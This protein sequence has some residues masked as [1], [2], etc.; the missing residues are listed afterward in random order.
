MAPTIRRVLL[1]ASLALVLAA[2][3][4]A[5]AQPGSPVELPGPG[6]RVRVE[7]PSFARGPLVGRVDSVAA[8]TLFL[9]GAGGGLRAIPVG[10]VRG[11][12]VSRGSR[13]LRGGT[14]GAVIGAAAGGAVVTSLIAFTDHDCDY[15]LG[16]GPDVLALAFAAGAMVR[17]L[18]G[19]AVGALLGADRWRP[20]PPAAQAGGG[21]R[22]GLSVRR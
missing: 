14:R 8:D 18:P 3:G 7:A 12:Q 4:A 10:A 5:A 21:I 6:E 19:A 13:T 17:V 1:R 20:L 22:V 2:P 11:V 16:R 9:R 15:C